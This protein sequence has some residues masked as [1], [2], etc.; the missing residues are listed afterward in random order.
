MDP[1]NRPVLRSRPRDEKS[2]DAANS[3]PG[4]IVPLHSRWLIA[5]IALFMALLAMVYIL[6]AQPTSE[7][8]RSIE[9]KRS[10]DPPRNS[11][12]R[13]LIQRFAYAR[14]DDGDCVAGPFAVYRLQ[15][16]FVAQAGRLSQ[17]IH[18]FESP[19]SGGTASLKRLIGFQYRAAPAAISRGNWIF[20][21]TYH[22]V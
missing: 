12:D 5:G 17:A 14:Q 13:F 2:G 19:Q 22:D 8:T 10:F 20:Q 7:A 9:P 15:R 18:A 21:E 16:T 11:P 3:V 4:L 1:M 6:P